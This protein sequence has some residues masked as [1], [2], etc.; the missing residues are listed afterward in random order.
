[1]PSPLDRKA[2][3]LWIEENATIAEQKDVLS[4]LAKLKTGEAWIWAPY[5]DLFKRA[6]VRARKTFDSSAAPKRGA[7]GAHAEGSDERSTRKA[8]RQAVGRDR[9]GEGRR[10]ARA[11]GCPCFSSGN[12]P[13]AGAA[14][15]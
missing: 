12:E 10:P 13:Q 14:G 8:E 7:A 2:L 1:L 9:E 11:G 4:S 6:Q 5:F 3:A 15:I